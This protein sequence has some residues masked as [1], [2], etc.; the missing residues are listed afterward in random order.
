MTG[1]LRA[2][3]CRVAA[4]VF[5]WTD[6]GLAH[7]YQHWGCPSPKRGPGMWP[8][9]TYTTDI[10]NAMEILDS[11]EGDVS[12]ERLGGNWVVSFLDVPALL[13]KA[14]TARDASLPVAICLARLEAT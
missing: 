4:E 9:P 6:V 14:A 5:G 3:D 13:G 2:L 10:A 1:G 11:W 7:P 12:I 8:V